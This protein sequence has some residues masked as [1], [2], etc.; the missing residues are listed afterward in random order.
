MIKYNLMQIEDD[1]YNLYTHCP[2][3]SNSLSI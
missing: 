3:C 2:L 1:N